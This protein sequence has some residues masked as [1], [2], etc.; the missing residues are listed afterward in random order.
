MEETTP[1][2]TLSE[3]AGATLET[4]NSYLA[5]FNGDGIL[6]LFENEN[7]KSKYVERYSAFALKLNDAIS[8]LESSVSSLSAL[9]AEYEQTR[10]LEETAKLCS[11]FEHCDAFFNSVAKFIKDNEDNFNPS[12]QG[13]FNP[14]H[15]LKSARELKSAAQI[16]YERING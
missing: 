14:A 1:I 12:C 8:L 5:T 4:V 3:R 7:N 10:T 16:F 2:L 11:L 9:I 13:E 15:T 6:R